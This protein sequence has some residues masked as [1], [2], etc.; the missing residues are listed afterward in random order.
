MYY[1]RAKHLN[2]HQNV[3]CEYRNV[4]FLACVFFYQVHIACINYWLITDL[5]V[6]CIV[7][8]CHFMKAYFWSTFHVTGAFNI[9]L[10]QLWIEMV[11]WRQLKDILKKL[12]CSIL[13]EDG[14][15]FI[16]YLWLEFLRKPNIGKDW[17]MYIPSI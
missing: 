1:I 14:L 13:G 8:T 7:F 12:I 4:F 11:V 10:I 2:I 6:I 16:A 17:H 15:K 5:H 9:C 3:T